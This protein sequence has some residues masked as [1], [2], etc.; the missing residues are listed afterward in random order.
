MRR[1]HE[2][3]L[4]EVGHDITNSGGTD[5]EPGILRESLG[6][7]GLAVAN[8]TVD[9]HFQQTLSTLARNF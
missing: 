2:P 4:F 7:H 9:E 5:I 1:G 3:Q 6:S 8:I